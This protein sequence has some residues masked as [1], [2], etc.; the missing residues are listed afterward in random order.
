ML[1]MLWTIMR[2]GVTHFEERPVLDHNIVHMAGLEVGEAIGQR[3]KMG[4]IFRLV[5][6]DQLRPSRVPVSSPPEF[7]QSELQLGVGPDDL[8]LGQVD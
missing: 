8:V 3:N 4:R 5:E 6:L 1:L 2:R 7:G